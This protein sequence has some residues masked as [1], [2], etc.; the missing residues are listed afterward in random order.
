M[1][2]GAWGMEFQYCE[3]RISDF[4]TKNSQAEIRKPKS[5]IIS[6][7]SSLRSPTLE[8]LRLGEAVGPTGPEADLRHLTS[9]FLRA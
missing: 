7:L 1:E 2:H 3:L 4:E 8:S 9:C 5:E 6:L